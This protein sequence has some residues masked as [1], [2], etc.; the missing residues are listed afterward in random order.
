MATNYLQL[1]PPRGRGY[2]SIAWI[3]I[4]PCEFGQ[5]DISKQKKRLENRDE[6]IY[7]IWEETRE[8][9]T[10]W[11]LP[12][13]A[14]VW[15]LSAPCE[16]DLG[17]P[18]RGREAERGLSCLVIPA[19]TAF[20]AFPATLADAPDVWVSPTNI[21]WKRAKLAQ[22]SPAQRAHPQNCKQI[23]D[24]HSKALSVGVVC[25]TA[26][27]MWYTDLLITTV[28]NQTWRVLFFYFSS[29]LVS[30]SAQNFVRNKLSTAL[31]LYWPVPW[32]GLSSLYNQLKAKP[33][34]TGVLGAGGR[35]MQT[36]SDALS[37]GRY[38]YSKYF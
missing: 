24:C 1:L 30:H 21:T 17:S 34:M 3:W 18:A 10:D 31:W 29:Y 23:N 36:K 32:K 28:V 9:L 22:L 8:R 35:S 14:S 20:P 11:V 12:Y 26:K 25:Y 38:F 19:F 37:Y 15:E 33:P 5:W 13:L 27:A 4:L 7:G 16:Q 2:L 6:Q